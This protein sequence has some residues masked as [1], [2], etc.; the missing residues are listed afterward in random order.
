MNNLNGYHAHVY[1]DAPDRAIAADLR[2]KVSRE[3]GLAVGHLH[4]VPVGPHPKGMFQALVPAARLATTI[5]YLLEH[6]QGLDVLVHADTGDDRN[7][8]THNTIWLG[9]SL[10]LDL[11]IFDEP[12]ADAG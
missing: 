7:D 1:F 12:F 2:K 8:H 6:R 11:S 5:E 4:G 3:L 9:R 10:P